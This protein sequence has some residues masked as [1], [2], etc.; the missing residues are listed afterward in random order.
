MRAT[1][2]YPRRTT[3]PLSAT[4]SAIFVFTVICGATSAAA[5][6]PPTAPTT[7]RPLNGSTSQSTFSTLR[8]EC[9]DFDNDMA[10]YDVYLGLDATPPLAATDL[11]YK[12]YQP[13][14][15]EPLSTYYWRVVAR[16][17]EGHATSSPTWSFIT[18][19]EN[20]PPNAP[21]APS[22]TNGSTGH[23]HD[24]SLAWS[25]NDI[26]GDALTYSVY[27]GTDASPPLLASGLSGASYGLESLVLGQT[28][29]WRIVALDARGAETTGTLWSFATR[30]QNQRPVAPSSP[31]PYSGR[32]GGGFP[33]VSLS[34]Q[35]SDPEGDALVYDVYFGTDPTPTAVVAN[36]LNGHY[37]FIPNLVPDATYYWKVIARDALG[38]ETPGPIWWFTSKPNR[39]PYPV[40]NP[41][42]GDGATGQFVTLSLQADN[43]DPDVQICTYDYYLGTTNPPPLVKSN[44]EGNHYSPYPPL[45]F[46]TQY[47]WKVV[48]R[49]PLG[50]ES[51]GPV[52]TFTT[53]GNHAPVVTWS[54]PTPPDG[55]QGYPNTTLRWW[56]HDT[57]QQP[58][59]D[60]VYFGTAEPLPLIASDVT[61]GIKTYALEGTLEV[62]QKYYWRIVTSDGELEGT[63]KTWSFTV[64][65]PGS[66]GDVDN[67]GQETMD[68]VDCA[69]DIVFD[70]FCRYD[71]D[72]CGGID[73]W[74]RADVNCDGKVTAR[75]ARCIHKHML[76]GSCAYCEG[77][78]SEPSK[79]VLTPIVSTDS[80][81][82]E[83]DSL[84]VRLAVSNVPALEAFGFHVDGYPSI[85]LKRVRNL[86]GADGLY[87]KSNG[88]V[89]T[90]GGY[91]LSTVDATSPFTLI[92]LVYF[93]KGVDR[94]RV[95]GFAD[96]LAGAPDL[97]I[98][99]N[100]V[101]VLFSAFRASPVGGGVQISW[102]L[103]SDEVMD[104]FTLYRRDGAAPLARMIAQ[105]SVGSTR[106]AYLDQSAQPGKTYHYE[107]VIETAAGN[108]FRSPVATATTAA[109]QLALHQNH[110][111]PFNPQTTIR[112]DIP[113][114]GSGVRVKLWIVDIAGR[115]VRTLVDESQTAG[116]R[117]VTWKGTNDRGQAVSSGVYFSV[118]DADGERRTRKLVLLK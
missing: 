114:R 44:K 51:E 57:D 99:G 13:A 70:P 20:I 56:G 6:D 116:S 85:A 75:D 94:V 104:K 92:E 106:G 2:W 63:G 64:V 101:P 115:L 16:D 33:G 24:V 55:G 1:F 38:A 110:P 79:Q 10:G 12:Y 77:I 117:E 34:W 108:V 46:H 22:P 54:S 19:P 26:D 84:F 68:D 83:Y 50:L 5:G 72:C 53:G 98:Q 31:S 112:Y 43:G 103:V 74:I 47:W 42:P 32:I 40:T 59:V 58:T 52:W 48:A 67:D 3:C 105:G 118:L 17:A 18:G 15:L 62:G 65:E 93:T 78:S 87:T 86:S 8:W 37:L 82:M 66:T 109:L 35:A 27:F 71:K 111:N 60:D 30:E 97:I 28:Y 23:A 29:Y 95:V 107:L 81:W 9:I 69:M 25:C 73:S 41:T 113:D 4:L 14:T 49:D 36:N 102:E 61:G 80:V 76:D 45:Q 21:S 39:P 90:V 11:T 88:A 100:T 96:D 7:P 89:T 91:F